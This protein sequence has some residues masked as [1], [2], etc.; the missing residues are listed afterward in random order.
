MSGVPISDQTEPSQ[1]PVRSMEGAAVFTK[2][3]SE[4]D[5][6]LF[7]GITG[8]LNAIHTNEPFAIAAG[9]AGR[10][11]H[12]LFVLGLMSTA[13]TL[14]ADRNELR[15]LSYGWEGVRFIR[16]VLIGDTITTA[17]LPTNNAPVRSGKGWKRTA[18][19]EAYNQRAELVSVGTHLLYLIDP[20][21]EVV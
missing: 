4:A 6:V 15:I 13:C 1:V 21:S 7:G 20:P 5:I 14:Y 2:T 11:A 16:P 17:Y 19:A 18:R 9:M 8:D 12:G 10:V 3:V